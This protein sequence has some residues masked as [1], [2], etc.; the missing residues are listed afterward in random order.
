MKFLSITFAAMLAAAVADDDKANE[1]LKADYAEMRKL[2]P[3]ASEVLKEHP[4]HQMWAKKKADL[5]AANYIK[6][7]E[8]KIARKFP[9]GKQATA[10]YWDTVKTFRGLEMEWKK[11]PDGPYQLTVWAND[12]DLKVLQA[13]AAAE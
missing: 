13:L 11:L 4:T 2:H 8:L 5:L 10:F 6:K 12:E 1:K 7:A 3:V 9:D